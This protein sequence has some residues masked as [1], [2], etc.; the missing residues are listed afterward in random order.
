MTAGS[1]VFGAMPLSSRSDVSRYSPLEVAT[2]S[3]TRVAVARL[4]DKLR[5]AAVTSL[6]VWSRLRT[7]EVR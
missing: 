6:P 3:A 2:S 5:E 4:L 1:K 7:G